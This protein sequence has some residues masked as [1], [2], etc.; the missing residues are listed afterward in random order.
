MASMTYSADEG[1][2]MFTVP[3]QI[4]DT[5]LPVGPVVTVWVVFEVALADGVHDYI[6]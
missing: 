1:S 6:L 4:V 2:E 5:I 3:S